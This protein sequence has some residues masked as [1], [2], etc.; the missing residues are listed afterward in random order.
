MFG[1]DLAWIHPVVKLPTP[2]YHLCTLL[3]WMPREDEWA[4][5]S[6]QGPWGDI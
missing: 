1:Q 5:L 3:S 2:V 4:S 6:L